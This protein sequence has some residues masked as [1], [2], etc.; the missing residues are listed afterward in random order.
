MVSAQNGQCRRTQIRLRVDQHPH[1]FNFSGENGILLLY[2]DGIFYI[3]TMDLIIRDLKYR[4]KGSTVWLS[5]IIQAQ[6]NS[7]PH[8]SKTLPSNRVLIDEKELWMC[9]TSKCLVTKYNAKPS[10]KP[11]FMQAPS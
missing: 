4:G 2:T 10:A 5:D 9:R 6:A 7:L 3:R 11:S 1:S 8:P